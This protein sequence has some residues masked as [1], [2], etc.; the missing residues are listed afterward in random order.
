M[1]GKCT[2]GSRAGGLLEYCYYEKEMLTEKQKAML[3]L[4]DV[5]GE[6]MYVQ[7]LGL[8]QLP[9]GRFDMKDLATQFID[10]ASQNPNLKKYVWH[11]SFSFPKDE[12]LDK[13]KIEGISKEFSEKFGFENNQLIVF[14][15]NDT[16]HKHFH[17]VAN[18]IDFNGKTTASDSNNFKKIGNF[19]REMEQK[20]QL[21]PTPNMKCLSYKLEKAHQINQTYSQSEIAERIK[22][23][24]KK[25]LPNAK[26]LGELE[27]NLEKDKIKMYQGR[28]VSFYDKES[29]AKFKG[30]DLGREFSLQNIEKKLGQKPEAKTLKEHFAEENSYKRG[31]S[32][33]HR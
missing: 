6:V 31:R 28:G 14:Q 9:D 7:N 21:T 29:K 13:D 2:G 26:T 10:C 16:D 8:S 3:G 27:Q 19:C 20:F 4:K 22:N 23:T 17:I 30:S 5:R 24:I 18:R 11:Q 25:H 32:M 1:I 33:G 12:K 15:H